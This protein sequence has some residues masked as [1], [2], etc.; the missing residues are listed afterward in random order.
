[1]PA[2]LAASAATASA[3]K[4]RVLI[5]ERPRFHRAR[6]T[7]AMT[8]GFMPYSTPA[9]SGSWP[10]RTYPQPTTM[11]MIVAGM[12]NERPATRRPGQPPRPWPM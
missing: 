12:M 3:I 8:T 10:Y 2:A 11:T 7:I 6:V 1:M 9:T 4:P 5:A